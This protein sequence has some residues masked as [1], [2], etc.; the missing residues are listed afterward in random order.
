[1]QVTCPGSQLAL[2]H[3]L[4]CRRQ[5]APVRFQD[6]GR[7]G[8]A[9]RSGL[10]RGG[11]DGRRVSRWPCRAAL[12]QPQPVVRARACAAAIEGA[13]QLRQLPR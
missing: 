11:C 1:M 10:V 12:Q 5:L 4:H 6:G 3:S 7:G 8:N 2:R 13:D 9:A